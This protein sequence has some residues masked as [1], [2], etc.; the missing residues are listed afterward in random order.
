MSRGPSVERREPKGNGQSAVTLAAR[1]ST[2]A[3]YFA[4]YGA[5]WRNS[6]VREMG[7]KTNFLLWIVVELL[8]FAL[9]LAFVAVIY[10]H[11]ARIGDWSQWEVVLLMGIA[12][13][14]Q[15]VFQAF[16]LVNCAQLS[17]YVRTG[18]LDFML[19][20][21]V[22][23]RFVVSLRQVD[24]GAFVNAVSALAIMGYAAHHLR[25]IPSLLQVFGFVVLCVAFA[26]SSSMTVCAISSRYSSRN[27]LR[28]RWTATRAV[29]SETCS[30]EA[31][32]P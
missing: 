29:P 30:P 21:P 11:T 7:F 9:Q 25:L 26:I 18:R 15:Q 2:L 19:L 17:E 12:H 22:N 3:R 16:F 6:V 8:W 24:L 4:L 32:D 14:I 31:I 13:F 20:L 5:L 10:Q 1:P 28:K 27:L 23:T